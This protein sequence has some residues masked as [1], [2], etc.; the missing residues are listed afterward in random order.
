MLILEFNNIRILLFNYGASLKKEGKAIL[1]REG[2]AILVFAYIQ[3]LVVPNI[4]I[5]PS[6][7]IYEIQDCFLFIFVIV[8]LCA[9]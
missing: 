9:I 2:K 4:L 1:K 7:N 6:I 3:I 8:I 5:K